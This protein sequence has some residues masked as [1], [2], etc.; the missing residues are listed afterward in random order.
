MYAHPRGYPG[1]YLRRSFSIGTRASSSIPR[2]QVYLIQSVRVFYLLIYSRV[3]HASR[4][5]LFSRNLHGLFMYGGRLV[6]AEVV[7]SSGVL[8]FA[9]RGAGPNDSMVR[10]AIRII[11]VSSVN[12]SFGFSTV[13]YSVQFSP[14]FRGLFSFFFVDLPTSLV[15]FFCLFVQVGVRDSNVSIRGDLPSIPLQVYIGFRRDQCVRYFYR[16]N[17]VERIKAV[18]NGGDRRFVLVRLR[19][20]Y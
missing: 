9:T 20:F 3:Y 18:V 15:F 16:G 14:W 6:F 17:D 5:R 12:V 1:L 8:R 19:R 2:S 7:F 4:N 11:R 10:R 13:F